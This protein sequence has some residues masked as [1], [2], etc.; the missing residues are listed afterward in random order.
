MLVQ[1]FL[2]SLS[3][4]ISLQIEAPPELTTVRMRLEDVDIAHYIEA[5][6]A[7]GGADQFKKNVMRDLDARRDVYCPEERKLQKIA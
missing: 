7:D 6:M 1:S 3:L 2:L 5:M 4:F